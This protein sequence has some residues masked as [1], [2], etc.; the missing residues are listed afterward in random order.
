MTHSTARATRPTEHKRRERFAMVPAEVIA[1]REITSD[2]KVLYAHLACV[3]ADAKGTAIP[4][5]ERL[6]VDLGWTGRRVERAF[7]SLVEHRAIERRPRGRK[8]GGRTSS[9]TV[10]LWHRDRAGRR[11]AA[12]PDDPAPDRDVEGD[13][14]GDGGINAD[15]DGGGTRPRGDQTQQGQEQDPRSDAPQSDPPPPSSRRRASIPISPDPERFLTDY[16]DDLH[17]MGRAFAR[18]GVRRVEMMR[19]LDAAGVPS[20]PD[21]WSGYDRGLAEIRTTA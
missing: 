21:L 19:L 3:Y 1:H 8:G 12:V 10:L 6:A 18:N 16:A 15:G 4:G 5:V 2:G 17:E 11:L 14:D 9:T 20:G 13:T 7:A